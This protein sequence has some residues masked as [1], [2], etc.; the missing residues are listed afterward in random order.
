[1]AK[2]LCTVTG[3]AGA[4][5]PAAE[6]AAHLLQPLAEAVSIDAFHNVT[7][8]IRAPKPG[9]PTVLLEAHLDEIGMIVTHIDEKGFLKVAPCGGMDRRL[10]LGQEVLVQTEP[11]LSGV[12]AT[13]P[14]HLNDGK[15]DQIPKVED[16]AIDLGFSKEEAKKRVAPGTLV[17][18]RSAFHTLL[19]ERIASKA[20]DDRIGVVAILQAVEW[21]QEVSLACGIS[22]LFST[23]EEVGQRGAKMAGYP[24]QADLILSLDVS[25]AQTPDSDSV[26]SFPLGGGVLIGKSP[27]LTRSVFERLEEVAKERG[28]AYHAEVMGGSTGTNADTLGVERGGTQ[29][30]LLSI[31]QRYMHTPVEVVDLQDVRA[32]ATLICAYLQAEYGGEH[33]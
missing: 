11:P 17:I 21:L 7:G 18:L 1:M 14:P 26:S 31:P 9:Q 23:Q 30:G 27:T 4:E 19:G 3:V 15:E 32:T 6:L 13:I 5:R 25:F 28:I 16:I 24:L 10:L 2:A 12:V 22:V 29:I 20:L 8:V 33:A